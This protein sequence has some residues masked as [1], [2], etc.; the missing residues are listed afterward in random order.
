ML[1]GVGARGQ[2]LAPVLHPAQRPAG[3]HR[4]P[5]H[6]DLLGLE[7]TLVAEASAH[8]GGDDSHVGL[9]EPQKLREPCANE[10]RHLGGG[11]HHELPLALVVAGEHRLAFQRRH[12]LAG[13]AVLALDDDC[14]ALP[15]RLDVAV[16]RGREEEV[17]VPL[18]VHARSVRAACGEAVGDGRKRFEVEHHLLGDVLGLGPR[19]G[20]AQGHALPREA[21]LAAGERRIV[22][23]LVPGQ[24]RLGA[25]R[26]H[27]LHVLRGEHP[28][29]VPIGDGDG[30]DAGVGEGASNER[31]LPQA[32]EGEI[33]DEL[34]LPGQMPG[35]FLAGD[36]GSDPGRHVR[37]LPMRSAR[38]GIVP[39]RPRLRPPGG[40][41]DRD[42]SEVEELAREHRLLAG[43]GAE[44][45][46]GLPRSAI[47]QRSGPTSDE[48]CGTDAAGASISHSGA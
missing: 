32:R 33:A 15:H 23:R 41:T 9:V 10:M 12:A 4:R 38:V 28:A 31:D 36:A 7:H 44:R 27:A 17:V 34:R 39:R 18:V 5:R 21:H 30:S 43:H 13:G 1:A 45:A 3:A 22:R 16:D 20:D 25:D 29:C 14:G 46:R 42:H 19:R 26:S 48:P 6:R 47:L 37:C 2:V 11:V 24:A 40:G 35:V 8:I